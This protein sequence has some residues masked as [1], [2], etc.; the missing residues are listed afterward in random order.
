[1]PM[2]IECERNKRKLYSDPRIPPIERGECLCKACAI[3]A[4]EERIEEVREEL[5]LLESTKR[6]ME[7]KDFTGA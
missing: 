6:L 3:G 7:S 2:C 1:M 4:L 5:E